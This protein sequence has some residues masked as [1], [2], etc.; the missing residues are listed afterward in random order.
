MI[1]ETLKKLGLNDKEIAIYLALLPLG[2]APASV[3]GSRTGITRSTAQYTCQQLAKKGIVRSIQNNNAFIYSPESPDKIL[4]LLEQQKK[5]LAEK[6]DQANRIIG[7]L[8]A[9]LNP[10]AVLP[11]VR[12]FEGVDGI[13][14]M[15]NDVLKPQTAIFGVLQ[16]SEDMHLEVQ[17]YI[18]EVYV[19]KR[20]MLKNP[21]WMLFNDNPET[22]TYRK[23]DEGMNRVTMLL[24]LDEFPFEACCHIYENKVAFYSYKKTDVT[25]V[26]IEN[27][28][29]HTTTFSVFKLAW[30]YARS[31]KPNQKYIN[32]EL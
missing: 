32:L 29:I 5:E 3:L 30:N 2:N 26:I 9:M 7:D 27:P 8:K 20:K 17:Q 12:F 23:N 28:H 25:G 31:L 1:E 11:K 22:Q 16:I 14:E 19:P 6:E 13:K 24:P 15:F 4:Y 21:S 18:N 10:L